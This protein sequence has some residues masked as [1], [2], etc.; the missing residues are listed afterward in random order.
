MDTFEKLSDCKFMQLTESEQKSIQGG[1]FSLRFNH[2]HRVR[3][4]DD[5]TTVQQRCSWWGARETVD[6]RIVSGDES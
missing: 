4:N 1:H 3:V 5:G 6:T 2:W